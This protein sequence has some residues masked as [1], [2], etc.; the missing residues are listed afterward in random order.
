LVSEDK[1]WIDEERGIFEYPYAT[2]VVVMRR[3]L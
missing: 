1:A 2:L 3:K